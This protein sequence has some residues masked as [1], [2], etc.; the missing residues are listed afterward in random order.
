MKYSV[1]DQA[2]S[3]HMTWLL[4]PSVSEFLQ[5]NKGRPRK[6]DNLLNGEE[7]GS[8]VPRD[9]GFEANIRKYEA[10]ISKYEAN[11][12]GFIRLFRIEA[13]QRI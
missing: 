4:P 7:E 12:T 6:R 9:I 5:R 13:N 11:K 3:P 8:R 2:F 1:E 10:N